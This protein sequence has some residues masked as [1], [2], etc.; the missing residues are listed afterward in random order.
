MALDYVRNNSLDNKFVIFSDP[1]SVL[2]SLNYTFSK[3]PKIQNLIENH[4]ELTKTKEICSVGITDNEAA[5]VK[6][7]FQISNL[8]VRN[9]NFLLTGTS[10][11]NGRCHGTERH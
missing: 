11:P 5:D 6:Q 1:L 8:H 3:S 7:I 2:K 10:Y 9:L 4:H